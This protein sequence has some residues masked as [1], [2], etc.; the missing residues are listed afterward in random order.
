[1]GSRRQRAGQWLAQLRDGREVRSLL[2]RMGLARGLAS[3]LCSRGSAAEQMKLAWC[4]LHGST[5]AEHVRILNRAPKSLQVVRTLG[6]RLPVGRSC[7]RGRAR[8]GRSCS[9]GSARWTTSTCW[10]ASTSLTASL[11]GTRRC[12]RCDVRLLCAPGTF[13]SHNPTCSALFSLLPEGSSLSWSSWQAARCN[14]NGVRPA[15]VRAPWA[16]VS[17]R[18]ARAVHQQACQPALVKA[19]IRIPGGAAR[20]RA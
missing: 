17:A 14:C 9:T 6:I 7:D 12:A 5:A 8:A 10:T 11:A 1:M 16:C 2:G 3:R 13:P 20:S 4:L 15:W 19:L 18:C